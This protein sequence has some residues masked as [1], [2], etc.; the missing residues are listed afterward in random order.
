MTHHIG[1]DIVEI[2]RI[3]QAVARWGDRFLHRVYTESELNLCRNKS[4]SLAVRFAGKEAAI[5]ALQQTK[6]IGWKHIE[7][8][9]ETDGK[10]LLNF[11]GK[12]KQ[13]AEHLGLYDLAITLSHSRNYAIAFV[14]GNAEP[15]PTPKA[16]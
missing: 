11:Y 8:L 10:P 16:P 5:K 13:Q 6:G 4:S 7:I 9:S 3:R 14:A 12:A 1:V 2:E 15:N